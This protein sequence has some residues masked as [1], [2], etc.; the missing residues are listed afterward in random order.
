MAAA[1]LK[2]GTLP[3][4]SMQLEGADFE[5]PREVIEKKK[6]GELADS[7]H[8][9]GLLHPL[10]IWKTT[11]PETK[12]EINLLVDG[13]RRW[14]AIGMNIAKK[15]SNGLAKKV[16]VRFVVAKTVQEARVKALVGNLHDEQL[17]SYEVAKS[18]QQ[19]K[20][21]GMQQKEIA[22]Q[23]NKSTTWVSRKL[24]AINKT[25]EFVRRAWRTGKLPDDDVESLAKLPEAEQNK[26]LE[27]IMETRSN[28]KASRADR[29]KARDVAKG[30]K[31]PEPKAVRPNAAKLEQYLK[32][33]EA[34]STSKY[35][36]GVGDGI[37][38]ALGQIG[39]G[40]FQEDW[41][42]HIKN[43]GLLTTDRRDDGKA[44]KAKPSTKAASKA[45]KKSTKA[46]A[47]A[48]ATK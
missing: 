47:K 22:K 12:K 19:L 17:T 21:E 31:A 15:R 5:N 39:A 27:T 37:R 30:K 18:M 9:H 24:A 13:G 11:D 43:K 33:A 3:H 4:E 44:P 20:D 42:Q 35:V 32:I 38:F 40:E 25:T 36:N 10:V 14:R 2:H 45:K 7:I 1:T 26:R 29:A 28:E 41:L 6:I 34:G 23:V 16:P 46:K 8:H 48:K